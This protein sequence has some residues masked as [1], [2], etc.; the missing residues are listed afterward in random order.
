MAS[1][2]LF[3]GGGSRTE[4]E[5]KQNAFPIVVGKGRMRYPRE[6]AEGKY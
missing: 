5:Q 1:Q 4:A 3:A 6:K 2:L